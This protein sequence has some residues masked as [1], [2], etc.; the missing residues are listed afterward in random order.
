VAFDNSYTWLGS[1]KGV[2]RCEYT[3]MEF[4]NIN[5]YFGLPSDDIF[6]LCPNKNELFIGTSKGLVLMP[7]EVMKPNMVP[8]NI[9]LNRV[10]VNDS[11]MPLSQNKFDL[12]DTKDRSSNNDQSNSRERDNLD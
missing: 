11:I 1:D 12:L 4:L 5:K 10:M 2:Y 3:K 7:Y 9:R 6:A 8:P